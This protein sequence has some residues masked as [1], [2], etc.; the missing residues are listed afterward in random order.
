MNMQIEW[1]YD[2]GLSRLRQELT[3]SGT[4]NPDD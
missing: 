3:L 4:G 2:S 1:I